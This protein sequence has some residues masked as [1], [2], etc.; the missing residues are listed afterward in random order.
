[1]PSSKAARPKINENSIEKQAKI[2]RNSMKNR[3]EIDPKSIWRPRGRPRGDLGRFGVPPGRSGNA[4]RTL[5]GLS[6]VPS[7]RPGTLSGPP[8][9]L[10]DA[11]GT[12]PGRFGT[13]SGS[14]RSASG[15][16]YRRYRERNRFYVAFRTVF[17]RKIESVFLFASLR[18][19]CDFSTDL[20]LVFG[21]SRRVFGRM[22]LR[23]RKR[24]H[25][26]FIAPVEAKR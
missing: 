4:A 25:R 7:G 9:T 8:K 19:L 18:L 1:M 5:R 15:P 26:D 17:R 11:P 22:R 12:P 6:G 10:R 13:P 23:A 2:K 24:R 14:P 21:R 3:P 16:L 20:R